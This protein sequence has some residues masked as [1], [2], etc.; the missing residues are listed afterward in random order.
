MSLPDY[1]SYKPSG[2]DW[3]G[4]IPEH[5]K[6]QPLRRAISTP[7]ANGIFKKKDQFGSGT[8]LINVYN[9]Y[10]QD[11]VVN[12]QTLDRVTCTLPEISAYQVMP[13]DLFF[14]RSSLKEDGIAAVAMVGPAEEA[15]VFEC[16]LVKVRPETSVLHSRYASYLLNSQYCRSIMVAKAKITT[17]TTVD[18]EAI[19]SVPLVVPPVSE[20]SSIAAFLDYETA[21]IDGLV[22]E[23]QRLI[24]LLKEKREAVIFHAV[25]TGLDPNAPMKHSGVE[26]LGKVPEHWEI[27]R[28]KTI[29]RE[30]DERSKDGSEELLSVSHLTGVT[31]RS[32]K[33]V[34]MFEAETTEGYKKVHKTDF[35]INTLWAWMG[36]MGSS[37]YEGIASPNYH[38][39]A[40]RGDEFSADYMELMCRINSFVRFVGSRSRG[41]WSSRLRF[42]P[43]DFFE[44]TLPRP[45]LSDQI[46]IIQFVENTT[47]VFREIAACSERAITLLQERRSALISAAVTGKIDVRALVPVKAEAA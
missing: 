27:V 45:P 34:N 8:L 35:V 4:D 28:V 19:L 47:G 43:D 12:I 23:Q 21:K 32:E 16:H 29:Y 26:W 5:W 1:G 13:G 31:P 38:V 3:A 7:I 11:F 2:V 39:Y 44:L 30:R 24:E 10:R 42:Y 20:Q 6:I 36:A 33:T 14:V 37:K 41:V 25:T 22:E 17:M 15:V 18:Q 9:I 46:A 40:L